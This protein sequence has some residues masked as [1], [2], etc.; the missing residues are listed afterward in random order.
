MRQA[1]YRRR[2]S[3]E[4]AREGYVL[5]LKNRLGFFPPIGEPFTLALGG[6]SCR[7]R[8]EAIACTCR[9]PELPHEHYHIRWPGL[10]AGQQI[11]ILPVPGKTPRY[12]IT[13][14]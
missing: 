4:E 12:E 13:I 2:V 11:E 10:R 7:A 5:V 3:A 8:V 1:G 9:G 14:A 6:S